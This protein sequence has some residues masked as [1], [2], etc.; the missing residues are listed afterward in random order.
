MLHTGIGINKIYNIHQKPLEHKSTLECFS[1][2][3][4]KLLYNV[5]GRFI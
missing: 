3:S 5:V 2:N 4:L 1:F